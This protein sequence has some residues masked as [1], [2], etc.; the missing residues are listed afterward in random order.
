MRALRPLALCAVMLLGL[1]SCSQS[2]NGG[3]VGGGTG[4]AG[5]VG[6]P[7]VL[8]ARLPAAVADAG[9]LRV[10][11]SIGRAPLLFYGTGTKQLE[12]IEY[13]LVQAIGRQLGV[14]AVITDETFGQLGPDLGAK[15]IDLLISGFVDIKGFERSGIDFIDYLN[16]RSAVL[17]RHGSSAHVRGPD[18]LC[19]HS[20]GVLGGTAQQVAVGHL[21]DA[22]R[23]RGRP[24]IVTSIGADHATLLKNLQA[25]Q[26]D[27]VLDD[28]VVAQYTAQGSTGSGTLDVVG[29]AVDPLPYGIGVSRDA[30]MLRDAVQAA[31]R[32][33]IADGS[34]DAALSHWGG[35]EAALRSAAI[36][37]GP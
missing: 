13:E 32:N 18:D 34:Y 16:G 17:V 15:R 8:H 31:L 30:P 28:A 3:V 36:N 14:T 10:G 23:R 24:A 29:A 33:I 37:A 6:P 4:P 9:V 26:L 21:D 5:P 25:G 19:G 11:A 2:D 27:S 35:A 12:G 20:V 7:G 22:C 1:A